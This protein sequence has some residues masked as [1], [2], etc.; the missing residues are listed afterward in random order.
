MLKVKM[1]DFNI[2][3]VSIYFTI[4]IIIT[5]VD[6]SQKTNFLFLHLKKII[7]VYWKGIFWQSIISRKK[8]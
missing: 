7:L 8:G 5:N 4:K 1:N 2:I 6:F 3:K